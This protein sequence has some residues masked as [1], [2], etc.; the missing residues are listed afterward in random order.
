MSDKKNIPT[1]EQ[2]IASI[3][4]AI[5]NPNSAVWDIYHYMNA[6]LDTMDSKEA[7]TLLAAYFKIPLN[8]PSLIHSCMLRIALRMVEKYSD[9]RFAAFLHLWGYPQNLRPEDNISQDTD[10]FHYSS[11][12]ERTDGIIKQYVQHKATPANTCSNTPITG[13]VDYVDTTR[14]FYH[15]YDFGSRHFVAKNPIQPPKQGDFVMFTPVIPLYNKFKSAIISSI[16]QKNDGIKSFGLRKAVITGVNIKDGYA[17]W[18]LY[19]TGNVKASIVEIDTLSP[20]YTKGSFP[21]SLCN[22]KLSKGD[23]VNL[24]VYLKRDRAGIKRPHIVYCEK[25]IR[26]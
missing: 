8:R 10:G 9:F 21:L 1:W 25:I 2:L 4:N 12:K 24:I 13:Y 6:N 16:L 7:R 19:S 20:S 14:N 26:C 11:L 18:E 3:N 15:I 23:D 5:N 22:T 17:L